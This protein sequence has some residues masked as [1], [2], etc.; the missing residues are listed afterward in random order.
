MGRLST[1]GSSIPSL[2]RQPRSYAAPRE[3]RPGQKL[4]RTQIATE[5]RQAG[6]TTEGASQTS[7]LG[8]YSES[9]GSITIRPG[10]QS[11]HAQ[12]AATARFEE[13]KIASLTDDNGQALAIYELEPLLITGLSEDANRTKRR[14]LTF[15]E[16][17]PNLVHA[18]LAIEDRKFFDHGG[19]ELR[20]HGRLGVA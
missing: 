4:T 9:S 2:R 17:P 16:I 10:P 12:D 3:L 18:V 20:E 6:Y 14:L 11:Y 15:D 19:R 13:G 7:P 1:N 5:L 8:T